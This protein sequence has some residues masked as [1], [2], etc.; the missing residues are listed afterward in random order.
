MRVRLFF[1]PIKKNNWMVLNT[2]VSIWLTVKGEVSS[3][4]NFV[5]PLSEN[6]SD[7]SGQLV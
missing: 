7:S 6:G 2:T 5:N 3:R 4:H 1:A